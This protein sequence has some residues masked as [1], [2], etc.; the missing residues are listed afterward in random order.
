M[1]YILLYPC[2]SGNDCD[3]EF[4]IQ[5]PVMGLRNCSDSVNDGCVYK[6]CKEI[7][8]HVSDAASGEHTL[9][10]LWCR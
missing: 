2:T 10:S 8:D 1:K 6:S 4:C 5:I 7:R 9:D 3:S